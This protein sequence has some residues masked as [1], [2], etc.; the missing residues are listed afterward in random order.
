MSRAGIYTLMAFA[1]ATVSASA[2]KTKPARRCAEF[3]E[4]QTL[5]YE[6][7]GQ[8]LDTALEDPRYEPAAAAFEAI[9]ED[10]SRHETAV[11]TARTI[12]E[13]LARGRLAAA[14]PAVLPPPIYAPTKA[15]PPTRKAPRS[16]APPP[17]PPPTNDKPSGIDFGKLKKCL[18]IARGLMAKCG[19]RLGCPDKDSDKDKKACAHICLKEIDPVLEAN[20]CDDES[21]RNRPR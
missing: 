1:L 3:D 5:F 12:R 19:Q 13:G 15:A 16:T 8:T 9:A 14:R 21:L 7:S 2:C 18:D 11:M 20:D 4:A 10:C 6:V 17:A